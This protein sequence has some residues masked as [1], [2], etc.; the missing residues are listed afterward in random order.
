MIYRDVFD[1]A[2]KLLCEDATHGYVED[3]AERAP[4][5]L[6]TL[7]ME[8]YAADRA[9]RQSHGL[10]EQAPPT[11]TCVALEDEFRLSTAF[12]PAA[13]YYL[14][15]MLAMDENEVLGERFFELYSDSVSSILASLPATASKIV[16]SYH[17]I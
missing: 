17:L 15:A 6:A 14:S 8:C 4:Y 11:A 7:D 16:D 2:V 9:Y 10:S 1:A 3:Y 5:L 12:F 13:L